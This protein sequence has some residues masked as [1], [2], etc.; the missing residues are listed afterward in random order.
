[1][2]HKEGLPQ[3]FHKQ[4]AAWPSCCWKPSC[5]QEWSHFEGKTDSLESTW[6]RDDVTETQKQP[7]LKPALPL[8]F[9][10]REI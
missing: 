10:L 7:M 8:C 1:M 3:G 6:F 9:L 2:K 4:A 5:D